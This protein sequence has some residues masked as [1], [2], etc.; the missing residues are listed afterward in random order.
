MQF[1]TTD[2]G[3]CILADEEDTCVCQKEGAD[4]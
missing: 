2:S 1:E 3:E 4:D